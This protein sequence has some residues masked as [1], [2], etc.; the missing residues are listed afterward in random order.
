MAPPSDAAAARLTLPEELLLL[1]LDPGSGRVQ[2]LMWVRYGMAAAALMELERAGAVRP[3]HGGK[4]FRVTGA[5][6]ASDPQLSDVRR[7]LDPA[8][9]PRT[10][11]WLGRRPQKDLVEVYAQR[12][13]AR[14]AVRVHPH[15]TLR[16]FPS[17]RYPVTDRALAAA[18]RATVDAAAEST[19]SSAAGGESA[20]ADA[21]ALRLAALVGAVQLGRR[22][23]PGAG[24]RAVRHRLTALAKA[25]W[26]ANAVRSKVTSTQGAMASSGGGG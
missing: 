5:A 4:R 14:G 2:G 18:E 6:P 13:A 12:L 16:F 3:E 9:R 20:P 23:Y 26:V 15:R 17:T 10:T 21:R 25:D 1:A 22:L 11:S 7:A 19:A 24:H 8:D